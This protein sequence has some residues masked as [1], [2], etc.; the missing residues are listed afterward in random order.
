MWQL[1]P[2]GKEHK[3]RSS[4]WD[5]THHLSKEQ[6]SSRTNTDRKAYVKHHIPGQKQKRL[7]TRKDKGHK[8]D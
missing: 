3:T 2:Y 6:A 8:R 1:R 4:C 7:G 5:R